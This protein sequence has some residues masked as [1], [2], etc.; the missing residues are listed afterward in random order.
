METMTG[1]DRVLSAFQHQEPDKVP[2][3]CGAS[4]EFWNKAKQTL[5]LDDEGLLIRFGDDFRRV[6][7]P[8]VET[9]KLLNL[10]VS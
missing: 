2:R 7:A 3:W 10:G 9:E 5:N 8:C 1:R 4:A 6:I